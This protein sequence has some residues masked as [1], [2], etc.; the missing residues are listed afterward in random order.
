MWSYRRLLLIPLI[1][2]VKA[3]HIKP[4]TTN[5]KRVSHYFLFMLCSKYLEFRMDRSVMDLP[6][7]ADPVESCSCHYR[8]CFSLDI[9][10]WIIWARQAN[11]LSHTHIHTLNRLSWGLCCCTQKPLRQTH[12][13]KYTHIL[14]GLSCCRSLFV[15][16]THV[17]LGLDW[18]ELHFYSISV[19][20]CAT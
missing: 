17:L 2:C 5:C 16:V 8:H 12:P 18:T 3:L 15:H 20:N 4:T 1:W 11:T 19:H 14:I 13:V 7:V 10:N 6:Q 9:F